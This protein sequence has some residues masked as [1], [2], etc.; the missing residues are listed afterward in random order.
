MKYI[1]GALVA[2]AQYSLELYTALYLILKSVVS[3]RT[4]T[5]RK[6]TTMDDIMHCAPITDN[7]VDANNIKTFDFASIDFMGVKN[8]KY[9]LTDDTRTISDKN[10]DHVVYRIKALRDVGEFVKAGD[11]GGYVESEHNLSIT[12]SCWV[13]HDA[14]VY[15]DASVKDNAKICDKAIACNQAKIYGNA[16]IWDN[17]TI[18]DYA[19]IYENACVS[20]NAIVKGAAEVFAL[21]HILDKAIV[22]EK[23]RIWDRAIIADNA[24]VLGNAGVFDHARVL[25]NAIVK[26]NAV[27][28]FDTRIRCDAI[29]DEEAGFTS[30]AVVTTDISK[31]LKESIR[32]QLGMIPFNNEII[33]YKKVNKDLTSFYD[34]NFKYEIGKW[35]VCEDVDEDN[36]S[37]AKGLHF[38]NAT[39]FDDACALPTESTYLIAKVRLEDIITVQAGKI[40]CRSAFILGTYNV[41]EE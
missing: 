32:V 6:M 12:G 15:G 19:R 28:H 1:I 13:Y 29:V 9:E 14:I 16:A 20:G 3:M 21:A 33:V 26:G 30:N 27:V 36:R 40:R 39:S 41:G 7:G 23:A 10:G 25:D 24:Q 38:S 22:G 18:C 17:A 34:H 11:L 37:C 35:I 8:E 31:D 4:L 5:G 2:A